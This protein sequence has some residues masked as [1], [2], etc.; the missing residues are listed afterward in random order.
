MLL[1]VRITPPKGQ[2]KIWNCPQQ[3]GAG[4]Q[5]WYNLV[6][7][8]QG[9]WRRLCSDERRMERRINR[10]L[11][12]CSGRVLAVE[13]KSRWLTW[14]CSCDVTL[15]YEDMFGLFDGRSKLRPFCYFILFYLNVH[16]MHMWN[17]AFVIWIKNIA[18]DCDSVGHVVWI[19]WHSLL[20]LTS[21]SASTMFV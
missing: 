8:I 17:V 21:W 13:P 1:C 18:S 16:L 2:V 12:Q 10:F 20:S 11:W 15:F 9:S 4:T 14:P 7:G 5:G 19:M 3:F 6:P